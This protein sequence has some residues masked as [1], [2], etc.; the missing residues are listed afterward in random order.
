MVYKSIQLF[1]CMGKAQVVNRP[2]YQLHKYSCWFVSEITKSL[3]ILVDSHAIS[4]YRDYWTDKYCNIPDP[5]THNIRYPLKFVKLG[6]RK[7]CLGI[8]QF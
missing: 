8:N 2:F 4:S 5:I 1:R 7:I 6:L 3:Y